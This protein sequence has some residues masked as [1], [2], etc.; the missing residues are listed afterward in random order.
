M[1]I[2]PLHSEL[3]HFFLT[4]DILCE[5]LSHREKVQPLDCGLRISYVGHIINA[6]EMVVVG[7]LL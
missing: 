2:F 1:V 3:Q 5:D 6:Q 7:Q 4:S